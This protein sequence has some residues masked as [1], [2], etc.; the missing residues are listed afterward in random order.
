M[1]HRQN[2][3]SDFDPCPVKGKYQG[4]AMIQVPSSYLDWFRG[5]E[6]LMNKYPDVADYIERSKKAI[7]QDIER[8]DEH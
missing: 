7:D 8:E 2:K 3:L 4:I 5:Q 1:I 6:H